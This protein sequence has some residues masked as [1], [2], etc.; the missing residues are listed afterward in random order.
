MRTGKR[1]VMPFDFSLRN[2][3]QLT[4]TIPGE[5]IIL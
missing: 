3:L 1:R 4:A 2:C 5:L